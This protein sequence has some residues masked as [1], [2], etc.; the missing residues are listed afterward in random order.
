MEQLNFDSGVKEYKVNGNGILRFNPSDPNV[1]GR[2]LESMSKIKEVE[3]SAA[4]EAKKINPQNGAQ[5]AGEAAIRIMCETDRK[6][7]AILNEIFGHGNDFNEILDGVNLMAV[8]GNGNRVVNNV[9]DALQPI[10][11]EGIKA[12]AD[13]EIAQAKLNRAQRRAL[14]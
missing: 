14:Q 9:I 2:F 7:K 10:L 12:C 6:M 3:T 13:D 11:E 8:A 4:E 5:E 1:Y